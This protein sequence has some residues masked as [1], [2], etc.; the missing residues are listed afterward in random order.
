DR[1][2][3]NSF[4]RYPHRPQI[5]K[6]GL[7][8]SR[9]LWP[10]RRDGSSPI[11]ASR[12]MRYRKLRNLLHP[13]NTITAYLLQ[14][15]SFLRIFLNAITDSMP[16]GR[17]YSLYYSPDPSPIC[18][19]LIAS[20]RG[21]RSSVRSNQPSAPPRCASCAMPPVML[22]PDERRIAYSD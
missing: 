17:T 5:K 9:A 8:P 14:T 2:F 6:P 10:N 21:S 19:T 15:V 4:T 18:P 11:W 7:P 22:P 1:I 12:R 16:R 13:R 3:H 20:V